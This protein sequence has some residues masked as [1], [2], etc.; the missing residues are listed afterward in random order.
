R[1]AYRCQRHALGVSRRSVERIK[2]AVLRYTASKPAAA[3]HA[4]T[5]PRV[6]ASARWTP[7]ALGTLSKS[8]AASAGSLRLI[9]FMCD[10]PST[11]QSALAPCSDRRQ[12]H[13]RFYFAG[14]GVDL[15]NGQNGSIMFAHTSMLGIP[16][17][18]ASISGIPPAYW[19]EIL[20]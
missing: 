15:K 8:T 6:G 12:R 11:R 4:A 1:R 13:Q 9:L 3:N 10:Y 7:I 20:V 19:Y 16:G 2:I 18:T 14:V 5:P 17:F